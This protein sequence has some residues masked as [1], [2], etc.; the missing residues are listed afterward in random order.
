MV[1]NFL[2]VR[3]KQVYDASALQRKPENNFNYTPETCRALKKRE[4]KCSG[5]PKVDLNSH[6]RALC[7]L[8]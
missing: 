4:E 1:A 8:K 7:D 6:N 2:A 3:I 5:R